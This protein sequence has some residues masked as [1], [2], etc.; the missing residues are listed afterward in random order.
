ME[1]NGHTDP[2]V[3]TREAL[4]AGDKANFPEE[5]PFPLPR[6]LEEKRRRHGIPLSA[7]DAQPGFD[8]VLLWQV[9]IEEGNK[10][11]N[12]GL[13]KADI[14]VMRETQ[15]TPRG[16]IVSA[17]LTALDQLKS[18]G[19]DVGHTVYFYELAPLRLR[20]P[21]IA[22]RQVS[23]IMIQAKY[24]FGSEELSQNLKSRKARVIAREENGIEVH[25]Y[26]DENGKLWKP[27]DVAT[28]EV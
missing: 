17:G 20:R 9:Q 18:H 4:S 7:W 19:M 12:T 10:L 23:L 22:G 16:V 8:M 14:T 6:L 13:V 2:I 15:D 25:Y 27:A 24:I 26:C 3:K 5:C 1:S 21:S 11:G 28:E